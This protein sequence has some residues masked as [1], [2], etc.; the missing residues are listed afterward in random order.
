METLRIDLHTHLKAAKRTPYQDDAPEH[1]ARALSERSLDALAM[2]EH[3]HAA[4]FWEM[5]DAMLDRYAYRRG[6]FEV[7]DTLFYTGAE[8][9]LRERIDVLIIAPLA[10]L[11]RIDR[12][13]AHPLSRGYHPGAREFADVFDALGVDALRIGAHPLRPDKR[14]DRLPDALIARLFD[15]FEINACYAGEHDGRIAHASKRRG[16]ALTGGS[17]AHAHPGVGAAWT[18]AAMSGDTFHDLRDAVLGRRTTAHLHPAH[19]DLTRAGRDLKQRL[20]AELPRLPKVTPD[21][22]EM[23]LA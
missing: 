15:A 11:R 2:T 14:A 16:L 5:H 18:E 19:E 7:G 9:T 6:R 4:Q 13:F 8:I 12:A 17:D 22:H 10:D 20:K 1:F 21:A 3:F 23:A